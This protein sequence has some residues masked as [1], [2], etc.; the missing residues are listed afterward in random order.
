MELT[1]GTKIETNYGSIY[2]VMR[3]EGNA[4]YVYETQNVIHLSNVRPA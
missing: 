1:K 4:V 3:V 2:T